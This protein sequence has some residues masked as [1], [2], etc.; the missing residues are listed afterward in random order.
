M[1]AR[2]WAIGF[3]TLERPVVAQR[4]VRSARREFPGVP[5]YVADQSRRLG[6][7]A[8]FYEVE[9]VNVIRLPFDSGLSRS[10]NLLI[11][12]M[13]VDYVALCDDDFILGPAT[14]FESAIDVLEHEEELG[15][16]GGLL[17]EYDGVTECIRNWEMFFDHDE[18]NQRFTATPI[19][20]YP[21][22]ARQ[23]AGQTVY[24]CDAVLNFAVLRKRMF[25]MLSNSI[26]WE[27][28][29][30]INGEHED[31]YLNLK[32]NSAYRVAYLPTMAALHCHVEQQGLY[33]TMRARDDGRRHFMS[34]WNVV[35]HLEIGT[36]AHPL[37]GTPVRD[38]FVGHDKTG[39]ITNPSHRFG[40][41]LTAAPAG[42]SSMLVYSGVGP[43]EPSPAPEVG[44]LGSFLHWLGPLARFCQA[45]PPGGLLVCYQPDVDPEGELLLWTR[46][47]R[48]LDDSTETS[49]G[50]GVVM[51]W[52]SSS[53]D[54]LIWESETSP[55]RCAETPYWQPLSAAI[56]LWPRGAPYLRFEVVSGCEKRTPLATG[57]VFA[58]GRKPEEMDGGEPGVLA[59]S[60]TTAKAARVDVAGRPLAE[61]LA[62]ARR[63]EIDVAH[64]AGRPWVTLDLSS[65]ALV[66]ITS[67][68]PGA[69]T[70][71]LAA[72][73]GRGQSAWAPLALP[74]ALILD[75]DNV[76]FACET[77]S[78]GEQLFVV[79]PRLADV[80]SAVDA[81]NLSP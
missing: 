12:A 80:T 79:V 75:P 34:K 43:T 32:K 54:V 19:Y 23:V 39:R 25:A 73:S 17:H 33:A 57:F 31:F 13:D 3:V 24:I 22:I 35:S 46:V 61:L 60:R 68:K 47:V 1:T 15:V 66:G 38:W 6:P 45:I 21:A 44:A 26:R 28:H 53:G 36:G 7:M 41:V 10:R 64:N 65:L 37:D 49:G 81:S 5:I 59:L 18:R 8:E 62:T 58:G 16:V 50:A 67:G 42:I 71:V 70:L 55:I 78:A 63:T 52:F 56:P 40:G 76:L 20:N 30:K 48:S 11:E 4:F 72:G 69:P 29:I 27:E 74:L 2:T 9:R 51:R 14:S 77:G